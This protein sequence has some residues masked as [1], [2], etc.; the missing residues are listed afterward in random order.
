M[1]CPVCGWYAAVRH[2]LTHAERRHGVRLPKGAQ[3]D[4]LDCLRFWI[5]RMADTVYGPECL[6]PARTEP[7]R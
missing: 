1:R 2:M 6:T 3:W 4:C 7:P 5:E